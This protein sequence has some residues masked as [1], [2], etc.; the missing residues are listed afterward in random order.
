VVVIQI[1]LD[2]DDYLVPLYIKKKPASATMLVAK[3]Q[4]KQV[5]AAYGVSGIPANFLIDKN[6]TI[7][8]Y[9]SGFGSGTETRLREWIDSALGDAIKK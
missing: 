5:S 2:E 9:G 7:Q 8:H 4:R 6:G 3:D 1:S